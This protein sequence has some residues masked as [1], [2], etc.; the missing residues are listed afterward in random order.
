VE[1]LKFKGMKSNNLGVD[2]MIE[3]RSSKK[4]KITQLSFENCELTQ[5]LFFA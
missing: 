5:P 3:V 2:G 1:N 4:S